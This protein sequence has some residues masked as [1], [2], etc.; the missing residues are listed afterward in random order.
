MTAP[1]IALL[2]AV[3]FFVP[4]IICLLWPKKIQGFALR[5]YTIH[6]LLARI[7]P[8]LAWMKTR[9]YIVHL[10]ICGVLAISAAGLILFAMMRGIE[11]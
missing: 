8:F 2:A 7:N 1:T 3:V 9:N 4:G 10:R 6:P 5:Y 11:K